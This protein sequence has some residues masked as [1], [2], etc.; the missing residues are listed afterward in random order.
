[1]LTNPSLLF[2]DASGLD[3]TI[4]KRIVSTLSNGGRTVLMTIP[5]PSSR[6][7]CM[8][9]KVFMLSEGNL[10]YF[11]K[12]SEA[13]EYFSRFGYAPTTVMN[14]SDFLLNLANEH[15]VIKQVGLHLQGK[16]MAA[17]ALFV[18]LIGYRLVAYFSQPYDEPLDSKFRR[19]VTRTQSASISISMSSLESYE[20]ETSLVVGIEGA[21]ASQLSGGTQYSLIGVV[22]LLFIFENN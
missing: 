14:P 9:Q 5:Q 22:L 11:G 13:M 18:M 3:S 10:V 6:M 21:T 1:M 12:G 7:Y 19:T 2:L 16:I 15:P 8:F 4:A 17:L 20:K